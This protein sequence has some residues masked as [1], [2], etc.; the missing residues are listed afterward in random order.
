MGLAAY[1]QYRDDY[2]TSLREHTPKMLWGN[3]LDVSASRQLFG[4]SDDY[5]TPWLDANRRDLAHTGQQYW[6]RC[7]RE[8]LERHLHL[9]ENIALVGGCALNVLLNSELIDSGLFT[10]IHVCPIPGDGGQSLGAILFHERTVRA[11]WPFLGRGFGEVNGF[12]EHL[13]DDLLAAKLVAW[14]QGRAEA[15]PR[16]LGHR[17]VLGLPNSAEQ[18]DRMNRVKGREP[19]RPVAPLV[20]EES[21]EKFFETKQ[22]SPFMTF[23][24]KARQSTG[25]LAPA[26]VHADGTSRVQTLRKTDNPILHRALVEIGT[27][28]GAPILMNTSFN[29]A[30]E[31][32]VDTPDDALRSFRASGF[33]VLY[34]NGERIT[35]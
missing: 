7:F 10:R 15:G 13:V 35:R 32:M 22:L 6:Q 29:V 3:V 19:Y 2:A 34:I 23:G 1:G 16:A 21:L 27:E 31:A 30:G 11:D 18:R 4:L 33:D 20:P 5:R 17:S 12:P 26:I 14:Y 24:P 25:E 9:S 28:T 8:K